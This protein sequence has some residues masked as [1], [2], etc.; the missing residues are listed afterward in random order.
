MIRRLTL[1]LLF[2]CIALLGFA[3]KSVLRG[4]VK[5][6][7][8][9]QP[10]PD[11][12]VTV[13]GSGKIYTTD[14]SGAFS[15]PDKL[16]CDKCQLSISHPAYGPLTY[17]LESGDFSINAAAPKPIAIALNKLLVNEDKIP[18]DI[19]TVTL[20]EADA[21]TE[22][23]GDVANLL[24]A[25]RDVFQTVAGFGWS[26][27]RFRER[28][29]DGN[30]FMTLLNGVPINDVE[31]GNTPFNEFGGLNDVLRNRN[32]SIGLDAAELAF[33]DLG[34]VTSIDTRASQQ[35]KQTRAS[36]AISNRTYNHRVMFTTSTGLMPGGWAVSLSGSHRWAQEAYVPGTNFQGTSYFL[37]VDKKFGDRFGLNL[38]VLGSPFKRGRSADSFQ[39]M[40]DLAGTNYYNPL[41]GYWNG[42]KRN[43]STVSNNQPIAILRFDA[44]LTEKTKLLFAVYGQSGRNTFGAM[45]FFNARNPNPDFNRRLPS[46]LE[47]PRL[48]ELQAQALRE[49]E[50]YRQI[51]WAALYQDNQNNITAVN[52]ADGIAGNTVQ[53]RLAKYI[54]EDRRSDNDEAGTNVVLNHQFNKRFKGTFGAFYQYYSSRNYKVVNDLLGSDFWADFDFLGNFEDDGSTARNSDIRT[55]NNLIRE[56]ETFGW[57]YKEE[58]RRSSA[59]TQFEYNASRFQFFGAAEVGRTSY[60]RDGLMQNGRYPNN[61]LGASEKLNFTPYNVKGGATWKINGRNYLYVNGLYGKRAPLMSD[62]YFQPTFRDIAVPDATTTG[63]QSVEGGYLLRAPNFKAR[64]TG[65]L[66]DFSGEYERIFPGLWTANQVLSEVDFGNLG[67]GANQDLIL[68]TNIFLGGTILSGVDRRHTGI[69][70]AFEYKPV[71]SWVISGATSIGKFYYTSRP[72][73]L[74]SLDNGI[75]LLDAGEVYQLN[76]YVP[77]TPQTTGALSLKY[78]SRRFWFA[79]LSLNYADNM[80]YEFDRARRTA[81]YVGGLEEGTEIWN[82]ILDQQKAK[83]A[84]TLDFFGGKSWRIKTKYFLYLNAGVNNIL[85]NQNIVISG[86]DSYRN[87]FRYDISDARFYTNELTYAFGTNYFISLAVRM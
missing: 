62:I 55:P 59:W 46:S 14:A 45:N 51:N 50:N 34:G 15:I 23:G 39:E 86:R 24:H 40:Y 43:A 36:Y 7:E 29:Y 35:R 9:D 49:D 10:I 73:M 38:T 53:G 79:S 1:S 25:S 17:D 5:D 42:E 3:Q 63:V 56:G 22:G 30:T 60:W 69:E 61:S 67:N 58:S 28:G 37:S 31:S 19:P 54:L 8:N 71:P 47:D 11:A 72:K 66:T 80:W 75:P 20:E 27:F 74:L 85:N 77:R 21:E 78:E 76:Y 12:V 33:G 87:A 82:L 6:A 65:Y 13:I 4:V 32:S 83:S 44:N 26:A 18:A 84:F 70:A 41:W 57:D 64:F 68:E 2:S 52:N 81:R 48:A 16:N